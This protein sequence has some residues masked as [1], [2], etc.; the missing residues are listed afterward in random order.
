MPEVTT[1]IDFLRN[2]SCVKND[3]EKRSICHR[4]VNYVCGCNGSNYYNSCAASNA[5]I[6]QWNTG[7]CN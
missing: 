5:G 6:T 7:K 3:V 1:D 2:L 4:N